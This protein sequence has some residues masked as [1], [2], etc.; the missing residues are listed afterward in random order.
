MWSTK[1][2]EVMSKPVSFSPMF[3]IKCGHNSVDM[4]NVNNTI[5]FGWFFL[6]FLEKSCNLNINAMNCKHEFQYFKFRMV[7]AIISTKECSKHWYWMIDTFKGW[8]SQRILYPLMDKYT[9][10]MKTSRENKTAQLLLIWHYHIVDQKIFLLLVLCYENQCARPEG[11]IRKRL[12][13]NC[14][15]LMKLIPVWS[16]CVPYFSFFFFSNWIRIFMVSI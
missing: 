11:L 6:L 14:I 16:A 10:R 9:R 2:C 4:S 13:S 3:H 12:T 15:H 5:R 1:W 8:S 7:L